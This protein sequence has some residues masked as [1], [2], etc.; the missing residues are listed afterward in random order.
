MIAWY[1]TQVFNWF[2][3][4]DAGGDG[5]GSSGIDEVINQIQDLDIVGARSNDEDHGAHVRYHFFISCT[6]H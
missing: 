3:R 5:S 4:N 1:N 2:N 6:S